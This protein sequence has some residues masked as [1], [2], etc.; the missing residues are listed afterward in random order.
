[1]K[2]NNKNTIVTEEQNFD[3]WGRRRNP[4][5]WTYTNVS[6]PVIT[7]RGYT[8]H[9]QLDQFNL[10]NMNGRVYD[11]LIGRMLSPDITVQAPGFTQSYNRYSYCFNN[12]LKYTDPSG[13]FGENTVGGGYEYDYITQKYYQ[14]GKVVNFDQVYNYLVGLGGINCSYSGDLAQAI[15][16]I[17]IDLGYTQGIFIS[18]NGAGILCCQQLQF[19]V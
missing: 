8:G 10:I 13:W 17:W 3:A 7:D 4:S 5:N 18:N 2:I 9:E 16:V 14:D 1:M 11:P 19:L 6:K 12:P 15:F